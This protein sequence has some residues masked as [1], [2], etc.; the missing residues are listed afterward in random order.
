MSKLMEVKSMGKFRIYVK[1]DDGVQGIV[2]LSELSDKP[3][4]SIWG[5]EGI[6]DK[7]YIDRTSGAI[8]WNQDIELCPYSIYDDVKNQNKSITKNNIKCQ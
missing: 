2:D 6:F 4:F 1:F 5:R 3:V 7:V 8:A